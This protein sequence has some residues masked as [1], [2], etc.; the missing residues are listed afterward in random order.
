MSKTCTI[1]IKKTGEIV[2]VKSYGFGWID[3]KGKQ[4]HRTQ[5]ALTGVIKDGNIKNK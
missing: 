5:A 3:S 4:Y 1:R 2:V